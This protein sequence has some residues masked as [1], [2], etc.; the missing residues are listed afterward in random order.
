MEGRRGCD[1][2]GR[3]G[4]PVDPRLRV[5]LTD[6]QSLSQAITGREPAPSPHPS[7]QV[8]VVD[9][10]KWLFN[11]AAS[12]REVWIF[13]EVLLAFASRI[14]RVRYKQAAL[15]IAWALVVPTIS[16]IL[17]TVVL[18][19]VAHIASEGVPYL[20][21]ALCGMVAWGF[22]STALGVAMDSVVADSALLRKVYFPRE[23]LPFAAIVA[24]LVDLVPTFVLLI[25]FCI[26]YG[27]TPAVEWLALPLVP[28]LLVTGVAAY[29]MLPA[30]LNV[31]YRDIRYILPFVLQLG[32]FA[33]PVLWSL[34][35]VA[36][37]W[38]DLIIAVNPAACAIDA[39]R[40]I[41]LHHQWPQLLSTVSCLAW[42]GVLGLVGYFCFKRLERGFADRI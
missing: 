23:V 30:S 15:G 33:S 14:I 39:L 16:A 4:L 9:A 28:I 32:L 17:F 5:P 1:I 27:Y 42:I 35:R 3:A 12:L 20:L 6:A 29:A 13:R 7:P 31:Y 11:V 38:R 26:A 19:R 34:T 36:Q 40:R 22:F 2:L 37:P 10:D 8:V 25:I 24:S 18:G 41:L 21:F